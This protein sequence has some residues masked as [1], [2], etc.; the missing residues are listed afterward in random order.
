MNVDGFRRIGL[1]FLCA[2]LT[3]FSLD[4]V[5][6]LLPTLQHQSPGILVFLRVFHHLRAH[7][8]VTFSSLRKTDSTH[9]RAT[10][11]V[12]HPLWP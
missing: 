11:N 5:W 9:R 2:V 7:R 4:I 10:C 8:C 12:V 6:N 1:T 3:P